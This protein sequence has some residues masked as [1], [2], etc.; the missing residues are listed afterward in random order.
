[1]MGQGR[2]CSG[3]SMGLDVEVFGLCEL[4]TLSSTA[5]CPRF[6]MEKTGLNHMLS[7]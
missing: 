3:E 7:G 4:K 1:M 6:P 5:Q 2:H